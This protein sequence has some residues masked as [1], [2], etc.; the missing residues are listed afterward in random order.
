MFLLA[1]GTCRIVTLHNCWPV[2]FLL[3]DSMMCCLKLSNM[4]V[5]NRH[6]WFTLWLL[7]IDVCHQS[8]MISV[9]IELPV[10][11]HQSLV[12]CHQSLLRL[13]LIDVLPSMING[14]CFTINHYWGCQWLIFCHE[15]LILNVVLPIATDWCFAILRHL[16]DRKNC[17]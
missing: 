3:S 5:F 4:F 13:S 6:W 2:R 10:I 11:N 17:V 1:L 8:L 7:M 9:C 14:S 16:C 12:F 15:S